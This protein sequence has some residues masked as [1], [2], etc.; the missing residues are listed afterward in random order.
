MEN[1]ENKKIISL[2]LVVLTFFISNANGF[3]RASEPDSSSDSDS[4][5]SISGIVVRKITPTSGDWRETVREL[6]DKLAE[7]EAEVV[8]LRA[9]KEKNAAEKGAL[10][11]DL[12]REIQERGRLEV[13]VEVAKKELEEWTNDV[14]CK[15][16]LCCRASDLTESLLEGN[17]NQIPSS[18]IFRS[19]RFYKG[20]IVGAVIVAVVLVG[21]YVYVYYIHVPA[22]SE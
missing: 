18:S 16:C 4:D 19:K 14:L 6:K 9:V 7:A 11:D 12:K 5:G 3:I 21:I 13:Q 1:H 8:V 20:V 2:L 10:E 22:G 15:N 17:I